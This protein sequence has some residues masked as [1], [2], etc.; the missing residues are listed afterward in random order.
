MSINITLLEKSDIQGEASIPKNIH[1]KLSE[2][3]RLISDLLNTN[4][5]LKNLKFD[6]FNIITNGITETE[7]TLNPKQDYYQIISQNEVFN[8]KII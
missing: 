3:K 6:N 8:Y 2:S 7:E 4:D 1:N 5:K